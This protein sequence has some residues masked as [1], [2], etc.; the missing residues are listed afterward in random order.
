MTPSFS[1]AKIGKK[2]SSYIRVNMVYGASE[3]S[4]KS[5]FNYHDLNTNNMKFIYITQN[6]YIISG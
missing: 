3:I 1:N 5:V 6:V 4:F 2:T